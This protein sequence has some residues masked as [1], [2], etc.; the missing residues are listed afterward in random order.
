MLS[1]L[2]TIFMLRNLFFKDYRQEEIARLKAAGKSD[3][4]IEALFPKPKEERIRAARDDYATLKSDVFKLKADVQELRGIIASMQ[5]EGSSGSATAI[6]TTGSGEGATEKSRSPKF[7]K[8][9]NI[10]QKDENI[11]KE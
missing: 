6:D 9:E 4:E 8:K 11:E 5:V 1:M 2:L 10:I 3:A 7:R